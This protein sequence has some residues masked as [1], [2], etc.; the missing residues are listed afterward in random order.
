MRRTAFLL[1]IFMLLAAS[2]SADVYI[3]TFTRVD[4]INVMGQSIPARETYTEEWIS[5]NFYLREGEDG[6]SYLYDLKKSIIYLILPRTKSYIEIKPPVNIFDLLPP[7]MSQMAQ[8]LE[9]MSL[10]V[11]PLGETKVINGIKS[12]G[13]RLEMTVMMYPMEMTIWAS[14]DLPVNLKNYLEKVWPE[15]LKIQ[16]R[17]AENAFSELNK[18][19]GLWIAYETKASFMGYEVNSRAEVLEI[20]SK[21]PPAGKYAIPKDYK[22]KDRLELEDLQGF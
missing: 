2:L 1:L 13:Y 10:S 8:A 15:I 9:Q 6:F 12:L 14:E 16:M 21:T 22:K 5:D 11:T 7:E 18:I 19:R 20:S 4:P 3:K 17:L